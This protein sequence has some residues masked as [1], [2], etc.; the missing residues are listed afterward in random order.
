MV[1]RRSESLGIDGDAAAADAEEEEEDDAA[2]AF[3]E[4]DVAGGDVVDIRE[5]EGQGGHGWICQRARR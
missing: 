4:E 5:E 2:L 3:Q 1:G